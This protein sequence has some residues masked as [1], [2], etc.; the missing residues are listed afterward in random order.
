MQEFYKYPLLC[1][2]E[3]PITG[4]HGVTL[5]DFRIRYENNGTNGILVHVS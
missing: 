3:L 1:V 4:T 5:K 2:I